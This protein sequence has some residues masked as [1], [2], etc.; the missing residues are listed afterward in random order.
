MNRFKQ[1]RLKEFLIEGLNKM[2]IS[3]PTPIQE[4]AIPA[5]LAGRDVIGR[6]QTGTGKTLAYLLPILQQID[7]SK[8]DL[9]ALVVVPT[10]ELAL[11]IGDTIKEITVGSDID[12]ALIQGGVDINRQL[13]Q[14]KRNPR[15]VIGT[16][17]RVLGFVEKEELAAY[18]ARFFV[19]DEAD[20]M[21]EMGF[22]E[23]LEKILQKTKKDVQLMFFAA[24]LPEKVAAMVKK[25]LKNP[26]HIQ[27]DPGEKTL[28]A[29]KNEFYKIRTGNKEQA[30]VRLI[31]LYNPFLGIVFAKKKED[32]DGLVT[33]L[34]QAGIEAEGFHGD[35]QRGQRKQ[36]MQRFR[37]AKNQILV[38]TDIASRGLDIEGVTHIFNFDLPIS[39]DQYI[40]RIGRT[41]RAGEAGTAISLIMAAEEDKLKYIA[42]KIGQPFEEKQLVRGEIVQKSSRPQAKDINGQAQGGSVKAVERKR[43]KKKYTGPN[44]K[45]KAIK[46]FHDRKGYPQRGGKR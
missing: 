37:E 13:Q 10:Q 24:T 18:K 43:K 17:G 2:G 3:E 44:A 11:Q 4:K 40:H 26:V 20:T 29:I 36:V 14:L 30:L 1:L 8:Q 28:S 7:L 31:Q 12:Y 21:L 9:Q 38:A 35:M 25:S 6:S 45:K 46:E 23:E 16:P 41:G 15:I 22:R 42:N 27:I 34:R 19:I 33:H 39:V 32:V 5:I